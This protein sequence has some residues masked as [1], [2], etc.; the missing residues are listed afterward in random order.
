MSCREER[1]KGGTKLRVGSSPGV[2]KHCTFMLSSEVQFL[3]TTWSFAPSC[4]DVNVK[5][6]NS[7]LL[8][9]GMETTFLSGI[10][11]MARKTEFFEYFDQTMY[12]CASKCPPTRRNFFSSE[13]FCTSFLGVLTPGSP[14][15]GRE[16]G[17][18][19]N[20]VKSKVFPFEG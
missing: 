6:A 13:A 4:D 12:I 18:L 16:Q 20:A 2:M 17:N 1:K 15:G 19:Q 5:R 8:R 11:V 3:K 9:F 14:K 7:Q 10:N